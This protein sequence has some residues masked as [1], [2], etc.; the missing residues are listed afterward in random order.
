MKCFFCGALFCGALFGIIY[1]G[2]ASSREF[3]AN[4]KTWKRY[5][6]PPLP[7]IFSVLGLILMVYSICVNDWEGATVGA[8]FFLVFFP[9]DALL[10]KRI[11]LAIL[12]RLCLLTV[13]V[14]GYYYV[15]RLSLL[16]ILMLIACAVGLVDVI[17]LIIRRTP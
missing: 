8:F 15:F 10:R 17:R 3:F 4:T 16:G 11:K 9:P 14:L 12:H 2:Y 5:F 1:V 7:T 13:C 6:R